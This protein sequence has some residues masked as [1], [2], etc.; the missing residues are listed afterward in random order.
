MRKRVLSLTLCLCMVLTLL[1]GT[2]F[3]ADEIASGTCGANLTWT[4][5]SGGTLRITGTGKMSNYSAEHYHKN[6]IPSEY[7]DDE[8]WVDGIWYYHITSPWFSHQKDIKHLV[9]E[10][11]VTSIGKYAFCACESI[12]DV[13][14]P[15]SLVNIG[16]L[17]FWSCSSIS[18]IK[19]PD[20]VTHIGSRAFLQC[21]NL[22]RADVADSVTTIGDGAF[23]DCSQL[24]VVNIPQNLIT[25][26]S[27]I[28]SDCTALE[29][30]AIPN[31]ITTISQLAFAGCSNLKSVNIPDSVTAI[32]ERAFSD[33]TSL[34]SISIP[35]SVTT[36]FINNDGWIADDISHSPF[37]NCTSMTEIRVD[38]NNPAYMAVDGILYN[39]ERTI[40]I[41]YPAGKSESTFTVPGSVSDIS[42]LAFSGASNLTQVVLPEGITEVGFYTFQNC[43][44][45]RS[46]IIPEGVT[47]LSFNAFK[48]C[49]SLESI[50]IPKSVT[51]ID[52][53]TFDN[54]KKLTIYCYKDSYTH[55]F[56]QNENIPYMLL[57]DPDKPSPEQKVSIRSASLTRDGAT[58]DLLGRAAEFEY[59]SI[60][61]AQISVETDWGDGESGRIFLIQSRDKYIELPVT[62]IVPGRIFEPNRSVYVI[63]TDADASKLLDWKETKLQI[64][65]AALPGTPQIFISPKTLDLSIGKT[66]AVTVTTIPA[67][68][69]YTLTSSGPEIVSVSGNTLTAHK[70]GRVEITATLADYPTVQAVCSVAVKEGYDDLMCAI[71]ACQLSYEDELTRYGFG[72]TVETFADAAIGPD[73]TLWDWEIG[74]ASCRERV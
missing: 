65:Q 63:A 20:G 64:V 30:I 41:S 56:A 13:T 9:I 49:T 51:Y 23:S 54:C 25:L 3:A 43:T 42:W 62:D 72:A 8:I 46:I 60:E 50:T 71:A 15:T 5:D 6:D 66:E 35:D 18:R 24:Y 4:L 33:C 57:D 61:T 39:K 7:G 10:D 2:A 29:H 73:R 48:N 31:G 69:R 44:S 32:G 55:Q 70:L 38:A 58:S 11:G 59:G 17:A 19:I 22:I 21:K 45:L 26:A 34:P 1:P 74:R 28:F 12:Q 36:F 67:G 37:S 14:M 27:G 47:V 53:S 52:T 68:A 40:L 16:N